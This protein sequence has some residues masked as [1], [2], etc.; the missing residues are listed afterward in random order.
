MTYLSQV[1]NVEDVS[2]RQLQLYINKYIQCSYKTFLRHT[3]SQKNEQILASENIK[4][5]W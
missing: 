2:H 4:N 5:T 1:L 3:G